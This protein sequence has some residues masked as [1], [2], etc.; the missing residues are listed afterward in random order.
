MP[1]AETSID[2]A[3]SYTADWRVVE[4]DP[5]TWEAGGSI[6]D[7]TAA[8]LS[9]DATGR[10]LETGSLTVD[11]E[12]T[13]SP[14]EMWAR[15]EALVTQGAEM[16]RVPVCTMLYAPGRGTVRYGRMSVPFD[17]RSAL[18]PAEDVCMQVGG[19]VPAGADGAAAAARIIGQCTPAP[20]TADGQFALAEA[21]VF[22][23]GTTCLEAA[24]MLVDAAG[25][26]I[27]VDGRGE[28]S[29][30]PKPKEPA[31]VLDRARA[32]MIAPTVE[33]DD[34]LSG[35]PN[36]YTAADDGEL[37][38]AV[39]MDEGRASSYPRLGRY[40]D[41]FDGSP[42]R[43]DGETLQAYAER[44]LAELTSKG[45]TRS[46]TRDFAPGVTVY[47]M[48]RGSLADAALVGNMR[49]VSQS[50]RL[51]GRLELSETSEVV[52]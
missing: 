4:V 16:E 39:D 12:P 34:G 21:V 7:A 17:G 5:A 11:M 46:Y 40:V 6:V 52:I 2:W 35:V 15:V 13:D 27:Q 30:R 49:I 10:L 8:S 23:E 44:K 43:L 33:S 9:R 14:T 51:G 41:R 50:M 25:W 18:A 1:A 45:G 42:S 24:W 31:L 36:R 28:I 20:I 19:Y 37:A 3:S 32:Q 29:I 22:A 38:T 26:C 47:D 48:V